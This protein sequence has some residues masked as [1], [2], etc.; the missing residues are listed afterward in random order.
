MMADF[1]E[2]TLPITE[3]AGAVLATAFGVAVMSFLVWLI[4]DELDK[5]PRKPI[6]FL[7]ALGWVLAPVWLFLLA[8]TLWQ[9]WLMMSGLD[10]D[11]K[12]SG[13]GTGALIAAM[14]GAPFVIWGTVLKQRTVDFQKEGHITDRINKAVEQLGAEK[15]VKYHY[16]G[17]SGN[18]R[19]NEKKNEETGKME[20]DFNN[21]VFIEETVP[22]IEVRIGAILSLERIAQDSTRYDNGRDHVRVMEILCAYVRGNAPVNS[23]KPE[24]HKTE[25]STPRIDIQTLFDVLKRRSGEQIA[26]EARQK[27][28]LNFEGSDL[29]GV[30]FTNGKFAGAI[31]Y[32]C[33]L[34]YAVLRNADFS[35]ARLQGCSL[36]YVDFWDADLTGAILDY[37]LLDQPEPQA[38]SRNTTLGFARSTRGVS[39]AAAKIPALDSLMENKGRTFG[40]RDTVLNGDYDD[41]RNAAKQKD[42]FA[43]RG[44]EHPNVY[45]ESDSWQLF[46][47]WSPFD[48]RDGMTP[49]LRSKLYEH[50]G[51]SGWPYFD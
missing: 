17:K 46:R 9:L 35:G 51:I 38:G 31:F 50:Y 5:E 32:S 4:L 3:H 49:F 29:R 22:N 28:R 8:G 23:K 25:E 6:T 16:K 37:C 34:Q 44:L 24:E 36:N 19:Y 27:Y 11:L 47:F 10:N 14:L 39:F 2:I 42:E 1:I 20:Q 26:I 41:D 45:D 12:G 40:T 13:L 18:L 33:N 7:I 15:T 21:P 30:N 43:E 48:S